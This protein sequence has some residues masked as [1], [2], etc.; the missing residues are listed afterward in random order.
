MRPR[1]ATCDPATRRARA[2][3]ACPAYPRDRPRRRGSPVDKRSAVSCERQQEAGKQT[4]HIVA[5]PC[6]L[7]EVT[8]DGPAT[9]QV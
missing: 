5:E 9:A 8:N 3:A 6:A 4:M 7:R 1:P 2:T